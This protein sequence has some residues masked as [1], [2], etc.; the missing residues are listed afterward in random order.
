MRP[1]NTM[2]QQKALI[3]RRK[4]VDLPSGQFEHFATEEEKKQHLQQ[5]VEAQRNH[6]VKF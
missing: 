2:Q 6:N 1:E 5:V 4:P 3:T